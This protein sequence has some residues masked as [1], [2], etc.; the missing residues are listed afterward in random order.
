M[1][2]WNVLLETG[3]REIH[4]I[5]WQRT[6]LNCLLVSVVFVEFPSDEIGY[7]FEEIFKQKFEGVALFLLNA[8]SKM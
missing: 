7:L 2:M 8:Y 1:E 5:K 4:I 3:E 6:W